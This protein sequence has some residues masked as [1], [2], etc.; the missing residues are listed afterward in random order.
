MTGNHPE[1]A[2]WRK[3][4]KLNRTKERRADLLGEGDENKQSDI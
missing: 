2:K 1:I 3:E 4:Q